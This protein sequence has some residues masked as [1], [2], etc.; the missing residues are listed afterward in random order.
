MVPGMVATHGQQPLSSAM[1]LT[2]QMPHPT[3]SQIINSLA[4]L[5]VKKVTQAVLADGRVILD[6]IGSRVIE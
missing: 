6:R 2:V 3:K 4:T 5:P 1:R